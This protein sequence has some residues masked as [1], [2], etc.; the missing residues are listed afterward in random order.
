[1]DI[2][3]RLAQGANALQPQDY[4]N[5]NQMVGSAPPDQF[6]RAVYGSIRQVDP[7]EYY[8]HIQPGVGGTDPLGALPQPQR[9]S[10]AQSLF[11]VLSQRGYDPNDVAYQVGARTTDPYNMSPNDLASL[12][13]WTHQNQP[14]AFGYVAS[15]YQNQPDILSSLLGNQ[16]LMSALGAIGSQFLSNRNRNPY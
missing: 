2:L 8:Q 15:Q 14:Q 1:M 10:L 16:A 5:W 3:Q 12:L 11:N 9:A 13:Q 7:Q 6:G 4:D